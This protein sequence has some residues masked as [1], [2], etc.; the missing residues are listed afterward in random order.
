MS[1][2]ADEIGA[3]TERERFEFEK[4][5]FQAEQDFKL[6]T[7]REEANA[8][9]W[10]TWKSPVTLAI[11]GGII[12]IL[13][14][15][16]SS[17][18]SNFYSLSQESQKFEADLI[19]KFLE[20]ESQQQRNENLRFLVTSG[21]VQRY[22]DSI[23]K[24]LDGN[25]PSLPRSLPAGGG[26]TPLTDGAFGPDNQLDSIALEALTAARTSMVTVE[27][28]IGGRETQRCSGFFISDH[29]IVTAAY[30]VPGNIA[31]GSSQAA[32]LKVLVGKGA[33]QKSYKVTQV[34]I[35]GDLSAERRVGLITIAEAAAD[36]RLLARS[37]S[38]PLPNDRLILVYAS[39]PGEVTAA[40]D[41][42][43]RVQNVTDAEIS[44]RCDASSGSAGGAVIAMKTGQI[45]GV[46]TFADTTARYGL[47]LDTAAFN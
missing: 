45:L 19:K 34:Q 41:D 4:Q 38:A 21:L 46:H 23:K 9:R 16:V 13:A 1:G 14:N 2:R 26:G 15:I 39:Q 7:W 3:P 29:D 42:E 40:F 35:R 30:C 20:P 43:C 47:R 31:E 17:T 37:S 44:Y 11:I 6:R 18:L 5:K 27:Q 36:V 24:Y 32:L 12:T 10:D 25:P 8:K 28:Q 33:D 22:G